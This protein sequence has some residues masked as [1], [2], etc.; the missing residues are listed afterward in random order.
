M[1]RSNKKIIALVMSFVLTILSVPCF[2]MNT[3]EVKAA[4]GASGESVGPKEITLGATA[5]STDG[6]EVRGNNKLWDETKGIKVYLGIA[7]QKD[8]GTD[9]SV[10][11][12]MPY[13]VLPSGVSGQAL[14]DCD[15]ILAHYLISPGSTPWSASET[16]KWL[17]N[18]YYGTSDFFSDAEKSLIQN[19]YLA[20]KEYD[21]SIPGG[22]T[23]RFVDAGF[24][25]HIF[26]LTVNDMYTYYG[27]GAERAKGGHYYLRSVAS[28]S[29]KYATVHEDGIVAIVSGT[30]NTQYIRMSPAMYISL[31]KIAFTKAYSYTNGDFKKINPTSEKSWTLAIKDG[32]TGFSATR[33]SAY[34]ITVKR[35][36]TIWASVTDTSGNTYAQTS[37]MLVNA[38]GDVLFYGK[39]T[40]DSGMVKAT[41][42]EG[43][44]AGEYTFYIFNE[45]PGAQG[46]SSYVSNMVEMPIE[47]EELYDLEVGFEET[48][49]CVTVTGDLLQSNVTNI[50]TITLVAD[51]NHY[52]PENY[53]ENVFYK[54]KGKTDWDTVG[55]LADYGVRVEWKDYSKVEITGSLKNDLRLQV[56]LAYSKED[57]RITFEEYNTT[58]TYEDAG[59]T[60]TATADL[61]NKNHIEQM[62]PYEITY[63]SS[64]NKVAT[65]DAATGKVTIINAGTFYITAAV[66]D[67]AC[68][69]G[70]EGKTDTI[71][72]LPK[73]ISKLAEVS[74]LE[75]DTYTY[76][77]KEW[78]P[79]FSVK[80]NGENLYEG[81]D[82][83]IIYPE[84]CIEP[85]KKTFVIEYINR[86]A[87]KNSVD[88][89]VDK[90]VV[91]EEPVEEP[92]EEPIVFVMPEKTHTI[93]AQTGKSSY[94]IT[95]L[96]IVAPEGYYIST[97]KDATFG[98]SVTFFESEDSAVIYLK[99]VTTGAI[100]EPIKLPAFKI[101]TKS[102]EIQGVQD[103]AVIYSST[104][105]LSVSDKNL[106]MLYINGEIVNVS[107]G[108]S[109]IELSSDDG[110][111]E[112]IVRAIDEAGN[113]TLMKIYVAESWTKNNIIPN[114]KTVKLRAGQAY[115]LDS[116]TWMIQGD[117]TEYNGG[118]KFYISQ[119][120][121][122]LFNRK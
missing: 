107:G 67:A 116:G 47:I 30:D 95:P 42:P 77:G 92:V 3:K 113:E 99:D 108:F 101:D 64:D 53:A 38:A 54:E 96:T 91:P 18:T 32:N 44:D 23:Y 6:Y 25:A 29:D 68:Y 87:G 26:S 74:F 70:N 80:Y 118:S 60:V 15:T 43:M 84:D 76:D 61:V 2:F 93:K 109:R 24:S 37:G 62:P 39:M 117:S 31:D 98:Q 36:G 72:V 114:A 27:S 12:P 9:R 49:D 105:E 5:L 79:K 28:S 106:S 22:V 34:P 8:D 115:T 120:G 102:P 63:S 7:A 73:D 14:L 71:K 122:Y 112:Y 58:C 4:D 89:M 57:I 19:T 104:Y 55:I 56:P 45:N 66:S 50:E 33:Q 119:E 65:V 1:K 10:Y 103:G 83:N 100:S 51:E 88:G 111:E 21:T 85:G 86:F 75:E 35:G 121:K 94:Y 13:R 81:V 59:F 48:N 52:F 110:E 17:E 90:I 41:I 82:Y 46:R 78:K 97:S 11:K 20:K 16:G 40:E 69:F